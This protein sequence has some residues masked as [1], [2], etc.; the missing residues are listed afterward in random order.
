MREIYYNTSRKAERECR[1]KGV[2][3]GKQTNENSVRFWTLNIGCWPEEV[4]M[5]V[6][7]FPG[8]PIPQLL[9]SAAPNSSSNPFQRCRAP[10]KLAGVS[11]SKTSLGPREDVRVFSKSYEYVFKAL[12]KK[13]ALNYSIILFKIFLYI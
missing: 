2:K 11:N 12:W 6:R 13:C 7:Q 3:H 4:T 10:S 8:T 9:N 1:L 5:T